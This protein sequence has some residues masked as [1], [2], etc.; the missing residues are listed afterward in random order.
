MKRSFK[1]F[2]GLFLA[3]ALL[4]SAMNVAAGAE[5]ESKSSKSALVTYAESVLPGYLR[6]NGLNSSE[7]QLSKSIISY[8]WDK[9]GNDQSLFFIFDRQSI[10]AQFEVYSY[11]NEYHST[12]MAG[13]FDE[14]QEVFDNNTPVAFGNFNECFIMRTKSKDVILSVNYKTD[15]LAGLAPTN[16]GILKP[17]AVDNSVTVYP[18]AATRMYLYKKLSV[19][20]VGNDNAPNGSGLCW[21]ACVASSVNFRKG[22]SLTALNVY[23]TTK[24]KYDLDIILS[25]D[26]VVQ[27]AYSLYGVNTTYSGNLTA[28]EIYNILCGNKPLQINLQSSTTGFGHAVL[29]CGVDC[30][31]SGGGYYTLMDPNW[32]NLVSVY[33]TP[34]VITNGNNFVYTPTYTNIVYN[35]WVETRY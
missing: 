30:E 7:Y 16:T 33:V 17:I 29:I 14:I 9:G 34:G 35:T 21:A 2:A 12:F 23:N 13:N 25:I 15:P 4:V 20:Y 3:L 32:P 27:K 26:S 19:K 10:V 22:T 31:T 8:D 24:A 1:R 18:A 28:G 5:G 6:A 11:E